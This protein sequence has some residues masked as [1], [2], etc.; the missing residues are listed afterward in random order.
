MNFPEVVANDSRND[1][2]SGS[3][4]SNYFLRPTYQK[5]STVVET[6]L[7][8][9][10]NQFKGLYNT[11]GRAYPDLAAQGFRYLVWQNG[12]PS[13]VDG[14]SASTPTVAGLFTLVNDALAAAGR[15]PMGFL[16]PWLYQSGYKAFTDVA[17]GSSLGCGGPG[18][19][20]G[21]GW[22]AASGF[23]T[24]DF[25]QILKLLGLKAPPSS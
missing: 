11:S 22:D 23:G 9:I 24:P 1:F 7:A 4:F 3:G 17:N 16:N 6:Y 14:T 18:F 2:V 20:A 10:G 25:G 21:P 5:N 12:T 13:S 19:G 8:S 15:S